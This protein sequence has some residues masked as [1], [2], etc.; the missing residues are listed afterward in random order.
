GP[1]PRTRNALLR[2]R[3]GSSSTTLDA[4]TQPWMVSRRSVA[5]NQRPDR[6]HLV[7][8]AD[9]HRV[10]G[11]AQRLD[12]LLAVL[13]AAGLDVQLKL[14]LA[15]RQLGRVARVQHLDHVGVLLGDD[16]RGAH[17]LARHVRE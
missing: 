5:W 9:P 6:V 3:P 2:L 14:D 13:D 15:D 7:A 8:L 10:A 11:V 4:A 12:D 16:G 17:E 1:I